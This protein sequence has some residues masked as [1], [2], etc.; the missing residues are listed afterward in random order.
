MDRK[1]RL[2]VGDVPCFCTTALGRC[3]FGPGTGPWK[4]PSRKAGWNACRWCT[5]RDIDCTDRRRPCPPPAKTVYYSVKVCGR[6]GCVGLACLQLVAAHSGGPGA[7]SLDPLDVAATSRLGRGHPAVHGGAWRSIQQRNLQCRGGRSLAGLTAICAREW[8]PLGCHDDPMCN[9]LY[10]RTQGACPRSAGA[11]RW[12]GGVLAMPV[13]SCMHS[14]GPGKAQ[15]ASGR[16]VSQLRIERLP[17]S[18]PGSAAM[19]V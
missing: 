4:K 17:R 11:F 6:E 16:C 18:K 12:L 14:W 19:R 9:H 8:G 2:R 7:Q 5:R 15:A 3:G 10:L 1:W 13:G